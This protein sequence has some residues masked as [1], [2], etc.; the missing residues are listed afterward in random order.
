MAEGFLAIEA[1]FDRGEDQEGGKDE[2]D[3]AGPIEHRLMRVRGDH[4]AEEAKNP[5]DPAEDPY[6]RAC[7]LAPRLPQLRRSAVLR[8]AGVGAQ[9]KWPCLYA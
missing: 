9:P 8:L 5:S 6:S 3:E 2:Q 4:E 7:H 1:L